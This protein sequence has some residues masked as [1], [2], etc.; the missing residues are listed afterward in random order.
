MKVKIKDKEISL[1]SPVGYKILVRIKSVYEQY[2][3][4]AI[5]LSDSL[6]DQHTQYIGKGE[7]ISLGPDA[8]NKEFLQRKACEQGWCK[9]GDIICF[10]PHAGWPVEGTDFSYRIINDEDVNGVYPK[11]EKL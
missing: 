7:V 1:P 6:K 2:N 3:I 10:S 8:Y 9:V 5:E 11:G 4:S